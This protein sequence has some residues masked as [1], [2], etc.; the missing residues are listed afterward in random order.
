VT[1]DELER[2]PHGVFRRYRRQFPF[3]KRADGTA[4]VLRNSDVQQLFTDP[5]TRQSEKEFFELRGIQG[6][7]LFDLFKYSMVTSN[8][9]DH[10]RRRSA[11]STA[12]AFCAMT[13][14]RLYIRKV[15]DEL[16]DSFYAEGEI[17]FLSRYASQLP[18][19]LIGHIL[20]MPREYPFFHRARVLN[21]PSL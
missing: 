17:D 3:I 5:R 9:S 21:D 11:F 16:I 19:C 12:F 20:S 18:A 10:R 6:G 4:L 14:L 8:G 13:D 15:A 1:I 2:D 7:T